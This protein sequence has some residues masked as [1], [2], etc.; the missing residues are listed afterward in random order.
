MSKHGPIYIREGR[1]HATAGPVYHDGTYLYCNLI[2]SYGKSSSTKGSGYAL[3]S[4]YTKALGVYADDNGTALGSSAVR[5]AQFRTLVTV[6]HSNEVSI[7]GSQSQ[8]K[9]KPVASVTLTTGNRAGSWNYLEMA[10][11][12]GTTITLSGASKVSAGAF[13][14]VDW[15]GVGSLTL[16]SG[17]YLAGFA[18]L[19]NI[20]K[21]GGTFTKT[22]KF[23]A[24]TAVNN[25]TTYYDKFRYGI[26]FP[27]SAVEIGMRIGDWVG[28]QASG[29]AILYSTDM[30]VDADG[31]LDVVGVF[32]ESTTNLT[33]AYSA[34]AGRFRH[35]ISAASDTV[36]SHE[37]YG[38]VGQLVVKN[39][40]LNHYHSG[41]MGTFETSTDCDIQTSYGVGAVTARPGGSG[42]TIESG[43][44]LAGFLAVQ[45]MSAYTAT[46][47]Y[48][49]FAT[50][51]TAAGAVWPTGLYIQS[52]SVTNGMNMTTVETGIKSTVSTYVGTQWGD[53]A[54]HFIVNAAAPRN[55]I[56]SAGYFETD[57]TGTVA[58]TLYNFGSWVNMMAS[59][60]GGSNLICAQDNGIW[61]SAT[62]TPMATTA[63]AI[64]GMRMEYV[65]EGGGD[66]G[67]LYLFST[68][69]SD[70]RLTAMFH[71]NAAIDLNWSSGAGS[72]GAGKIPLFRDV[73]AG[74][75]W[76]V[77]VYT[78]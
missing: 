64:I 27:N 31:Q 15:D 57:V 61:V 13:G 63:T 25:S 45:N 26:Y 29:S 20:T 55:E 74:Q 69:I 66:P 23:C 4:T 60:S 40:S 78:S 35:L 39:G 33:S 9:I 75:T 12:A 42:C 5:A 18:A 28:S 52:G 59:S 14:M 67:A 72:A 19:T 76:Y 1:D 16:S 68:N 6:S 24:Y 7:F 51:K 21:T 56:G 58:G 17:H 43:G 73:T 38:L 54:N 3:T 71:V 10:G 77:S 65:A 32:S 46:G 48:A 44:L 50:H 11:T 30:N 53:S 41:I 36:F 37:T 49:A 2:Q 47:T 22:G 34:K 70:N 62:G 8:L